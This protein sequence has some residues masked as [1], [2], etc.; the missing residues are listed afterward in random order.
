MI[1]AERKSPACEARGEVSL[2]GNL[3]TAPTL[4][5][6]EEIN[7][8][9]LDGM[10]VWQNS[11]ESKNPDR[12]EIDEALELARRGETTPDFCFDE[13]DPSHSRLLERALAAVDSEQNRIKREAAKRLA[14]RWIQR[15]HIR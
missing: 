6:S 1:E 7:R 8:A 5:A 11:E 2:R 4:S 3:T 9:I 10:I 15:R 12:A 14:L 13:G